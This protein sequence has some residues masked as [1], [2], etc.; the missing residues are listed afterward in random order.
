MSKG[1]ISIILFILYSKK[2]EKG[3]VHYS[4]D[5]SFSLARKLN[6]G[7]V[8]GDP[9]LASKIRK[10]LISDIIVSTERSRACET[11]VRKTE[12]VRIYSI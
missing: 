12:S 9:E 1:I 4:M 11:V 7:K 8:N 2:G 10:R 5:G 3:D 6:A